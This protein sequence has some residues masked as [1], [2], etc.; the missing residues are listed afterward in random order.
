MSVFLKIFK[1]RGYVKCFNKKISGIKH[2]A[3]KYVEDTNTKTV[4]SLAIIKN[5]GAIRNLP[6]K[7]MF[8]RRRRYRPKYI[9][10]ILGDACN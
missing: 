2:R 7:K 4:E 3:L 5:V 1:L 9:V 6:T 10:A 8:R